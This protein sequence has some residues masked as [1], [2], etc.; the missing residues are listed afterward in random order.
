MN[1]PFVLISELVG[2]LA[3]LQAAGKLR[4]L[5]IGGYGL[6]GH[7]IQRDTRDVDFLIASESVPLVEQALFGL[8]YQR[9]DLTNLCGN[10]AHPFQDAIPV[11]LLLVNASTM[12]K[13][14]ADRTP[15][16][17]LGRELAV[18]SIPSYVALKLHAIKWNPRR[19]GKDASDIVRLVQENPDSLNQD[20]LRSLCDRFGPAGVFEKLQILL[21]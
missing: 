10:Y 12:D 5:L 7:A 9:M 8:G 19:F 11:D 15:H 1:D 20:E 18:P 4:F 16:V 14:W 2:K 3:E 17:F 21:S 13:L 6:E